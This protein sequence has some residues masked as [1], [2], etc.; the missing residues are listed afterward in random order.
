MV[1]DNCGG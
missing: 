1:V